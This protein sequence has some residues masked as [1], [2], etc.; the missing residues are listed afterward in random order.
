ML[1]HSY[2]AMCMICTAVVAPCA[3][4]LILY[5]IHYTCRERIYS[6]ATRKFKHFIATVKNSSEG[7]N[8]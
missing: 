6:Q 2:S 8:D 4:G 5:V 7:K 1:C 3:S